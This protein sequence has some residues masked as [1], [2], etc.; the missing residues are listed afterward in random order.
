MT[1]RKSARSS[2]P[3][4]APADEMLQTNRHTFMR[5]TEVVEVDVTHLSIAE[6]EAMPAA[7]RAGLSAIRRGP[8]V[9]VVRGVG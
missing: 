5:G 2:A 4:T 7:S 8:F 1:Q 6:W 3:A 9:E